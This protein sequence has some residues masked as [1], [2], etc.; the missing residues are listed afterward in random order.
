M[1]FIDVKGLEEEQMAVAISQSDRPIAVS[2]S[3][4]E[5]LVGV[6]YR[7]GT[8]PK[9]GHRPETR[10]QKRTINVVFNSAIQRTIRWKIELSKAQ[11][12]FLGVLESTN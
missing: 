6:T 3:R 8:E 5:V 11:R 9:L 10:Q 7:R 1:A 12:A 2:V 4:A